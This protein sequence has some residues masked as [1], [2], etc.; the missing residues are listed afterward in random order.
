MKLSAQQLRT[1]GENWRMLIYTLVGIG[2]LIGLVLAIGAAQV[3]SYFSDEKQF[4]FGIFLLTFLAFGIPIVGFALPYVMMTQTLE[5]LGDAVQFVGA[6]STAG[7]Q[8]GLQRSGTVR[9]TRPAGENPPPAVATTPTYQGEPSAVV[10]RVA[11]AVGALGMAAPGDIADKLDLGLYRVGTALDELRARGW[12]DQLPDGRFRYL[13]PEE[14]KTESAMVYCNTCRFPVS[15]EAIAT[16]HR[17]H[18]IRAARWA[19]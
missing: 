3:V 1:S 5:A 12:V 11:G 6:P 19:T 17:G 15:A 10:R 7:R 16:H 14:R 18:N 2:L 9:S 13:P 8:Q 4:N